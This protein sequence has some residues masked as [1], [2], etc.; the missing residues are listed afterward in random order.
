MRHLVEQLRQILSEGRGKRRRKLKMK[1]RGEGQPALLAEIGSEMKRNGAK[2]VGEIMGSEWRLDGK[3][4]H[5]KYDNSVVYDAV[6]ET[7]FNY[8]IATAEIEPG[9]RGPSG[10][11]RGMRSTGSVLDS[12]PASFEFIFEV[13]PYVYGD[14]ERVDVMISFGSPSPGGDDDARVVQGDS[15]REATVTW[16]RRR[17]QF[18][19]KK[20]LWPMVRDAA[21]IA[22]GPPGW[23]ELTVS[24]FSTPEEL[25]GG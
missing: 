8:P 21:K 25:Y 20:D 19:V 12:P 1:R 11:S 23:E 7:E 9:D 10:R 17:K 18:N 16:M 14:K 15:M 6:Y 24:D 3:V 22:G 2:R 5:E 13:Y 4:M